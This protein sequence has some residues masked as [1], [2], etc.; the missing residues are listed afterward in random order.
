MFSI[1]IYNQRIVHNLRR[2]AS[3]LS[4]RRN[5]TTHLEPR[6][7]AVLMMKKSRS[8]SGGVG[9]SVW[10]HSRA[11]L[12]AAQRCCAAMLR[13]YQTHLPPGEGQLE[14]DCWEIS[15]ITIPNFRGGALPLLDRL[16]SAAVRQAL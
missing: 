5:K 13:R 1:F 2:F 4:S 12:P 9:R 8:V 16:G 7:T 10:F 3:F 15:K 14:I 11:H 6:R